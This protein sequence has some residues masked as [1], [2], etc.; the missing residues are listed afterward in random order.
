MNHCKTCRF[1]EPVR[2]NNRNELEEFGNF[3]SYKIRYTGDNGIFP[4]K[5]EVGYFDY[6]EYAAGIYFGENFGCIHHEEKDE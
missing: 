2:I 1:Y 3:T 5:D 4:G 6:K